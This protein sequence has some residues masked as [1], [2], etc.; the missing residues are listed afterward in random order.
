MLL[1]SNLCLVQVTQEHHA[2]K[3][4]RTFFTEKTAGANKT[5]H[6]ETKAGL[7]GLYV[8][9]PGERSGLFNSSTETH[10]ANR[11][12]T[13]TMVGIV[14]LT[15]VTTPESSDT[16]FDQSHFGTTNML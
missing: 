12:L 9:W 2:L 10:G 5:K 13:V 16:S 3:V 15:D 8:N 1:E 14:N 4:T 6:N 7:G 11:L